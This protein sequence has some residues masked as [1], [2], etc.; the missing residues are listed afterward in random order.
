VAV[1]VRRPAAAEPAAGIPDVLQGLAAVLVRSHAAKPCPAP[2]PGATIDRQVA[3]RE[4]GTRFLAWA[5]VYEDR[6][7]AADGI[8]QV[9]RV[10]AVD[11][12][13]R[14]YQLTR[15]RGEACPVVIVDERPDPAN[16]PATHPGLTALVAATQALI[17]PGGHR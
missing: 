1:T 5:V 3:D 16:T 8:D 4:P 13:G 11:T 14:G 9:R 15:L 7:P 10:D 17:R 6:M 12:D 2:D